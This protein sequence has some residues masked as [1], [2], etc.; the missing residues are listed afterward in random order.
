MIQTYNQRVMAYFSL[1]VVSFDF[2]EGNGLSDSIDLALSSPYLKAG[3]GLID[4][5]RKS[6]AWRLHDPST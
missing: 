3:A 4:L 1:S 2:E 6:L 5:D